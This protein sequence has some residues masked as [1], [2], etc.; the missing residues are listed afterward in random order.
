LVLQGARE[1]LSDD[2]R[3]PRLIYVEVH[4]YA[5]SGPGTTS[6]SLLGLLHEHGYTAHF[7]SGDP[8]TKIER[9]GEIVAGVV[10]AAGHDGPDRR[11]R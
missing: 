9:Y 2:L 11:P 7:L 8:V 3:K 6:G 5:G 1:L 10:G 4:P